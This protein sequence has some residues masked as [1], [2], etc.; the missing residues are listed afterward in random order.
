MVGDSSKVVEDIQLPHLVED[1][2]E[3][4]TVRWWGRYWEDEVSVGPA[5]HQQ[6]S[7]KKEVSLG[8]A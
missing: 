7:L 2:D 1:E 4:G 5:I 3:D 8:G 6:V